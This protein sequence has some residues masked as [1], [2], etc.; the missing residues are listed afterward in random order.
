MGSPLATPLLAPP[1]AAAHSR[2]HLQ[3]LPKL[4]FADASLAVK[5]QLFT[6]LLWGGWVWCNLPSDDNCFTTVY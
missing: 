5:G 1:T 4:S 6:L 2:C 3:A